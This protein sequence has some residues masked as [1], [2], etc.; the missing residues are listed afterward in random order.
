MK[1]KDR[2]Y[3]RMS[4]DNYIK[5]NKRVNYLSSTRTSVILLSLFLY[6]DNVLSE[7]EIADNLKEVKSDSKLEYFYI[8]FPEY[9]I[10][11]FKVK[12][13]FLY[14]FDEFI[15]AF[16]N[17]LLKDESIYWGEAD[18]K[19]EKSL[20]LWKL[21][22]DLLNWLNTFSKKTRISQT[23]LLNYSFMHKVPNNIVNSEESKKER[24]GLLLTSASTE[25]IDSFPVSRK[26]IIVE[27]H[28]KALKMLVQ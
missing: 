21:D 5:L 11:L 15:S 27:N 17:A 18:V 3:I 16:L 23:L 9:F 8:E 12:E 24:K 20:R 10:K 26:P 25:F 19:L 2:V 28:I 14:S 6:Q 4:N 7:E 13:R 1:S 22:S